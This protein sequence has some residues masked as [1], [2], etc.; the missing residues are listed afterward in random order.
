MTAVGIYKANDD[1]G[2]SVYAS[3]QGMSESR[4]YKELN[5]VYI[6]GR[7]VEFFYEIRAPLQFPTLDNEWDVDTLCFNPI[8]LSP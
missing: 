2:A 3:S 4:D 7:D 1:V 8:Y 5:S 6:V